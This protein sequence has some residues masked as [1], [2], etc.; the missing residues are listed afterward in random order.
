MS[1]LYFT[2]AIA[3]RRRLPRFLDAF[4]KARVPFQ[5][6]TLG[7]GTASSELLD[8]LG[9]ADAEKGVVLAVAP[10][11]SWR[12]LRRIL[13]RDLRIDVPGKGI[14]FTVP[15]SS[16]GGRTSLRLLTRGTDYEP[17]EET[18]LKDTKYEL[19]V[20]VC[21][22]GYSETVMDAAKK[23]GAGGGTVI[24]S[25]GTG[26]AAAETF[27][28]ITLA[29]EKDTILIVTKT[30]G[31]NAIMQA[32][33]QEA[34]PASRAKAICFSLPVTDTAGLRLSEDE[35]EEE[36]QPDDAAPPPTE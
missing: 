18:V 19:I 27:M 20:A 17:E 12:A 13:T 35:D 32:I 25:K 23:A 14:A 16:V 28:G 34:G 9:V 4:K 6:V 22:Q 29:S 36:Q 26:V 15:L 8:M 2:V 5:N 21:E 33:L 24:R 3:E 10:E 1:R 30:A 11:E 31:K 7:R